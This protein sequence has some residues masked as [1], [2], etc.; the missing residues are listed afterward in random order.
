MAP[1]HHLEVDTIPY[2]QPTSDLPLHDPNRRFLSLAATPSTV[3][4]AS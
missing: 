3:A 1:Q 2:Q 4:A